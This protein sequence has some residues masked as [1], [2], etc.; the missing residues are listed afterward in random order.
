MTT[1]LIRLAVAVGLLGA[2]VAGYQWIEG[3]GYRQ[4]KAD[5][6]YA[7][8]EQHR[9]DLLAYAGQIVKGD[10]QH[11]KDR[12]AYTRARDAADSMRIHFPCR[13]PNTDSGNTDGGTGLLSGRVDQSF[14]RLQ[15][16]AGRI[17]ERCEKLNADARRANNLRPGLP[18]TE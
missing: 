3:K 15:G 17:L 9:K 11:E 7:A 6:E 16:R 14:A 18:A 10:A 1:W 4:G 5:A 2:L 8:A 12:L 13:E